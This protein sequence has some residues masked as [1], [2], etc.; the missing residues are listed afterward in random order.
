MGKCN[1]GR[2]EFK[3]VISYAGYSKARHDLVRAELERVG[4]GAAQTFWTAKTPA[5]E[6]LL[7]QVPH[8]RMLEATPGMFNSLLTH[9]RAI[10]TAY[11]LGCESVL[12][13]EDDVR[14][15]KDC[16]AIKRAVLVL[17]EDYDLALFD[18]WHRA[19]ATPEEWDALRAAPFVACC[20]WKRFTDLRSAACY[21]M[22]RR[23]MIGFIDLVEGAIRKLSGYKLKITDQFWPHMAANRLNC[24]CA[25]PNVAVQGYSDGGS[26]SNMD[27]IWARYNRYNIERSSYAD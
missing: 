21:A 7:Q 2:F 26:M 3:A 20:C 27:S 4:L 11:Q 24:Y 12:V 1:W 19:K 13:M 16:E 22:S 8:N 25:W 14:F 15:L 23:G 10:K 18:W 17:P 5:D 6:V 9:Y